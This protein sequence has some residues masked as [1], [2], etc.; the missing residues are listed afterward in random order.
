MHVLA[1]A[2]KEFNI[3]PGRIYLWGHSMGG[4][5][6]FHL[7]AKY[8]DIW[9]ALAVAAPG[10]IAEMNQLTRFKHISILVLQGDADQTVPPAG[11][12]ESVARMK[13][14][15]MQYRYIEVS[16]GDH[17]LF[18]SKNRNTLSEIFAFFKT[19]RKGARDPGDDKSTRDQNR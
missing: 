18:I 8:P 7:A 12:R 2:R 9:A 14:L 5:G 10:H 17:S 3:D 1:L 4:S 13:Q 11:T 19:T 15:G 16:G 6:T